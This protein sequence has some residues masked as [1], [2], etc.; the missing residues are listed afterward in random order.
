MGGGYFIK[1]GFKKS[2]VDSQFCKAKGRRRE[3]LL[4]QGVNKKKE[5]ERTPLVINSHPALSGVGR[6]VDSLW[7][8][9]QAS[10]DMRQVLKKK[11][12]VSYKRPRNLKDKLV[13]AKFNIYYI[14]NYMYISQLLLGIC[15]A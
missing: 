15:K 3:N 9:L 6:I 8:I 10:D 5:L 12:L 1:R 4:S 2:F 13:R 14:L 11:P 7:P